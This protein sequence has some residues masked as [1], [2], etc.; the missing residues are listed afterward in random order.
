[1]IDELPGLRTCRVCGAPINGGND[2]ERGTDDVCVRCALVGSGYPAAELQ[3][4]LQDEEVF[5][6]LAAETNLE[7]ESPVDPDNPPWGPL[8][9]L[10]TW[11][12]SIAASIIIPLIPLLL[13]IFGKLLRGASPESLQAWAGSA[14]ALLVLTIATFPAH[15]LILI[16]CW[17]IVTRRGQRP[18]FQTLGWNWAGRSALYW[19]LVSVGVVI[20]INVA[21]NLLLG[22]LPEKASPFE[23]L[24]KSSATVRITTVLL[25]IIGAPLV[26][27]VVYRG[28]LFSGLRKRLSSTA[29]VLAVTLI[30][31]AV[32]VPQYIGAWR[33]IAGLTLLSLALTIARARTSSVLPSFL[34]HLVNNALSS[35]AILVEMG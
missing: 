9:G 3:Q 13:I 8:T 11:A 14:S 16:F 34:I 4:G 33:T 5:V 15:V 26:E 24:L 12:F 20:A 23:E 17:A 31:V 35:I 29:T 28:V 19:S 7:P 25:A 18:F 10:S 32:H 21:S 1:M 30:F 27:E 6:P 2:T 22:W